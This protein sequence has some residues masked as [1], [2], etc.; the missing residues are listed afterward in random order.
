MNS[1]ATFFLQITWKNITI[2]G[3]IKEK[4][5]TRMSNRE[6]FFFDRRNLPIFI[7]SNGNTM[8]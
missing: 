8:L 7:E 1:F 4:I 5:Q 2:N 3:K 6:D